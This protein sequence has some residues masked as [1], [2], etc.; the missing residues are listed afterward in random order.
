M[1]ALLE[2]LSKDFQKHCKN[3]DT[4]NKDIL[5]N[6]DKGNQ[7]LLKGLGKTNEE[8]MTNLAKLL[9]E[10][11][12]PIDNILPQEQPQPGKRKDPNPRPFNPFSD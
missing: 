6:I 11:K 8:I 10:I 5:K 4:F 1:N 2:N 7:D 3:I 12:K 9:S